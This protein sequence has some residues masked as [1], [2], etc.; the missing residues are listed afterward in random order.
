VRG[1]KTEGSSV[2][3]YHLKKGKRRA[4]SL[5]I[6]FSEGEKKKK[7]PTVI[8]CSLLAGGGEGKQER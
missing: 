6:K 3:S 8:F 2:P 5:L 7:N 1:G 4:S